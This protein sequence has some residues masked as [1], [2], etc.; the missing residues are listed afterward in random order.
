[1][2]KDIETKKRNKILKNITTVQCLFI[3]TRFQMTIPYQS[4][5]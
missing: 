1:M 4:K 3:R 5:F 2:I